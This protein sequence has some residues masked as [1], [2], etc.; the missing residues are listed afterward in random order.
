M[1]G[2]LISYRAQFLHCRSENCGDRDAVLVVFLVM[3]ITGV[4]SI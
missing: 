4:Y 2:L 1:T 3:Q